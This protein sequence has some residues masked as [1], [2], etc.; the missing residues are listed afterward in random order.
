MSLLARLVPYLPAQGDSES[1]EGQRSRPASA[2]KSTSKRWR[3]TRILSGIRWIVLGIAGVVAFVFGCIGYNE[4]YNH[5]LEIHQV[6]YG[7]RWSD[8]VFHSVG[9]FLPGSGPTR[10]GLPIWLDIARFLATAVAGY[11]ALAGLYSLFRD[12]VQEIR[13]PFMRN[14][15][16]VCGLGYVGHIFLRDI[17]DKGAFRSR[18]RRKLNVVAIEIDPANPLIEVWRSSGIPV[19]VGDAQLKRTLSAAGVQRASHL[20]AVC[21]EDAA[22]TQI[23]AVAQELVASEH[24]GEL[25]CLARIGDPHMCELLR[26]EEL[27]KELNKELNGTA[28]LDHT[29]SPSSSLDFFNTDE[30]GARLWLRQF[31][32]F[33]DDERQPHLLV[34]RLDGLSVWLVRHAA[35]LWFEKREKSDVIKAVPLW[36]T[37]IDDDADKRIKDLKDEHLAL[38]GVCEFVHASISHR[39]LRVELR[40]RHA[41]KDAPPLTRAYVSAYRDED[42]LATALKLQSALDPAIPMVVALSRTQGVGQVI[43]DV[44]TAAELSDSNIKMF[45]T[46]ERTCTTDL[47][48]GGSSEPF[49]EAIHNR[50]RE[51]ARKRGK[52][53]PTWEKL[54]ESRKES[55]RAQARDIKVKVQKLRCTITPLHEWGATEF[56]F[57]ADEVEYL[58]RYE[59]ERWNRERE[60]AGWRQ[61]PGPT[62]LDPHAPTE[63]DAEEKTTPYMIAF[64]ELPEDIADYDRD[65]VRA[66]P[67]LLAS[68]GLQITRR[69]DTR[70][71]DR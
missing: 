13:V 6:D 67:E 55:S 57:T 27:N 3:I 58:A 47:V 2:P 69:K 5:L 19:I 14:H 56:E 44:D 36:I 70:P 11:A 60:D 20:L 52:K 46:L 4:Y 63:A 61:V 22:N 35:R 32:A 18:L 25:Q 65:F 24:R 12:R 7:P 26:S 31:R 64:D 8:D 37:I 68:A 17:R 43:K 38:E 30:I 51:D 21:A 42:A 28:D 66:I 45:P 16:V 9:L 54:D 71:T 10:T 41:Q 23:T 62:K 50:W 15:V 49:A 29:A 33:D 1:T 40:E 39:G 59:H 53:A 48:R 34:S